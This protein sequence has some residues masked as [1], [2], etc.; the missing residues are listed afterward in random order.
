MAFGHRYAQEEKDVTCLATITDLFPS[1]F[2]ST[3][4]NRREKSNND[5]KAEINTRFETGI[6]E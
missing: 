1:R 5:E 6:D 4:A 3:L 2:A